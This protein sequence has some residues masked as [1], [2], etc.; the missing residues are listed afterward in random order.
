M[1]KTQSCYCSLLSLS[2]SLSLSPDISPFLFT[3]F[4]I[5][6]LDDIIAYS[7]CGDLKCRSYAAMALGN[8][9]SVADAERKVEEGGSYDTKRILTTIA[10]TDGV[11]SLLSFAFPAVGDDLES[12]TSSTQFQA[13]AGL[14]GL[15]TDDAS[16]KEIVVQGGLEPLILAATATATSSNTG[17]AIH[18]C[19][20]DKEL[21]REVAATMR[22]LTL[23]SDAKMMMCQRGLTSALLSLFRIG[24]PISQV[25]AIAALG[26]LA[27]TGG[28][29]L[30]RLIDEG[31]VDVLLNVAAVDVDV[32]SSSAAAAVADEVNTQIAR[33][34]SICSCY[35][36][37]HEVLVTEDCRCIERL[38]QLSTAA[39]TVSPIKGTKQTFTATAWQGFSLFS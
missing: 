37:T 2:L 35:V 9:C 33:C 14:R 15:A 36:Q 4:V 38:V 25:H 17:R 19:P 18:Q 34:L 7:K 20:L 21:K 22:N 6:S 8:F 24:D 32:G 10:S 30:K 23:S 13:V 12:T 27:D 39:A 26:N 3:F 11:K 5:H 29:V 16:R 1:N 31:C 28:P